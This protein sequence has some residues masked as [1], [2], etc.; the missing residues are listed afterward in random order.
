MEIRF[1][2]EALALEMAI[3]FIKLDMLFDPRE[4]LGACQLGLTRRQIKARANRAWV[5][6]FGGDFDRAA[7]AMIASAYLRENR[8]P[9]TPELPPVCL[10][11][12]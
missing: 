3:E 5:D 1:E 11:D 12:A 2:Y 8:P 4:F 6:A 10:E 7:Q 9:P